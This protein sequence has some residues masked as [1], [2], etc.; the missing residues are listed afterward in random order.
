MEDDLTT[1]KPKVIKNKIYCRKCMQLLPEYR[2]ISAYDGGLIDS[3]GKFSVC[4]ICLSN[5]YEYLYSQ[6]NTIEKTIHRMCQIFNITFTNE[7]LDAT[8]IHVQ[9]LLEGGKNVN[10]VFSLYIMKLIATKKSMTK[11][12]INDFQY[13]DVGTIFVDKQQIDVKELPIPQDVIEFWGRGLSRG[14]MEFLETQYTNFKQTHRADTYAEIVLLKEVCMTMLDIK[15]MRENQ[16]DISDKVKQLQA[17]M[18]SLD[19]SPNIANANAANKG[20]DTF[21]LW[22]ADIEK[23][24]PAQWLKNNP[25]ADMFRDVTNTEDYFQK[26]IVRPLKNFIQGS[27]DFNIDDKEAEEMEFDSK[28]VDNFVHI[29]DG[30]TTE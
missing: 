4:K 26:Y 17:L 1:K 9:T 25:I 14:D 3:N 12:G 15:K 22:I 13:E 18:K 23:D 5:I 20:L 24:E 16:D 29:D 19:I 11:E 28:E 27:K 7:A 10:A 30:E 21:G 6:Y 2:F 8:K